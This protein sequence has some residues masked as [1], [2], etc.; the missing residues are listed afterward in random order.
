MEHGFENL[1]CNRVTFKKGMKNKNDTISKI[2]L[3]LTIHVDDAIVAKND[4]D[5]YERFLHE[6]L[7]V[8]VIQ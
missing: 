3:T 6:S 7:R 2:L 1:D 8:G 5:M 4:S